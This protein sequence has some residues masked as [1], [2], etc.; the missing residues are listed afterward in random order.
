MKK[1]ARARRFAMQMYYSRVNSV[2]AEFFTAS[3]RINTFFILSPQQPRAQCSRVGNYNCGMVMVGALMMGKL[4]KGTNGREMKCE[5]LI[6]GTWWLPGESAKFHHPS[7]HDDDEV[8]S[9]MNLSSYF[10]LS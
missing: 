6:R 10:F 4:I 1:I 5:I 9:G 7:Y 8:K 2:R 3:T